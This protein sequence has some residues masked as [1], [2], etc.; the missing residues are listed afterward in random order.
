[1][2]R[3]VQPLGVFFSTAA[4]RGR[5]P[6]KDNK[7]EF[8]MIRRRIQ[9]PIGKVTTRRKETR[10]GR[11]KILRKITAGSRISALTSVNGLNYIIQ[12]ITR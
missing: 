2:Y 6:N 5:A 3:Q 10:R 8:M 1:M 4:K 9:G 7:G 12:V 11:A